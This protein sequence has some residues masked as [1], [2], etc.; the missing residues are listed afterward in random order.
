MLLPKTGEFRNP[1]NFFIW[2]FSIL[3]LAAMNVS[4]EII[5]DPIFNNPEIEGIPNNRAHA[6][7]IGE[8]PENQA[9]FKRQI[10]RAGVWVIPPPEKL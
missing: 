3:A 10:K 7:I 5:H 2:R 8:K 4:Q 6:K 9:E 1:Y